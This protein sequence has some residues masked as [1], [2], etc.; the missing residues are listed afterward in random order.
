MNLNKV[1]IT[2]NV[3]AEPELRY[4]PNEK[5]VVSASL[6]NNEHYTDA[7]GEEQQQTTFVN[8]E[9][10]GKAAENFGK[11]VKKGQE[12]VVEGKLRMTEWT[13]KQTNARRTRLYILVE[14]W[15]FTQYKRQ[16]EAKAGP[17][18]A[19]PAARSVP[20]PATSTRGTV[21]ADLDVEP[22]DIPF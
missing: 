3:T 1:I 4:T 9:I 22:D 18:V 11:L 21:P 12:L 7:R 20:A 13:D 6:A 17:S 19:T 10:W 2:G 14:S 8:L 5:A 16:D 15:Q